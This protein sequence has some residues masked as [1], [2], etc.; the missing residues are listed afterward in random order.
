M[1]VVFCEK[2]GRLAL[3]TAMIALMNGMVI[4]KSQA[5]EVDLNVLC[6]E[7]PQNTRCQ[8]NKTHS[9]TQDSVK[10]P[11]P[12]VLK[13]KLDSSGSNEWI[14]IKMSGNTMK[15]QHTTRTVKGISQFISI[16]APFPPLYTWHDHQTTRVVFE[17][18]NCSGSLTTA[19]TQSSNSV[20]IQPNSLAPT[21]PSSSQSCTIT[22]T[23]SVNLPEGTD[24]HKGMFT[25]NYTERKL[26]RSISFRIPEAQKK[27]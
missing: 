2:L 23:D 20:P 27:S 5:E 14:L 7:F 21:Q 24:I 19:P 18:D 17:P 4:E 9:P 15:F 1:K 12:K 16:V 13:I 22:G 26:L 25:V 3:T 10:S 8:Q 6:S 11:A